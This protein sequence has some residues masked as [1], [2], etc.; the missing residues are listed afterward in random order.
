MYRNAYLI[1]PNASVAAVGEVLDYFPGPGGAVYAH[2]Q[3]ASGARVEAA[4]Q[5][6]TLTV[7]I[8]LVSDAA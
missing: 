4:A 5:D 7:P 3:L 2:I 1:D 8:P 6:I